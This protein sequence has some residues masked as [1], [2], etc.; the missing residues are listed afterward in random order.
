MLWE[1][2]DRICGKR[3]KALLP[4][5]IEAMEPVGSGGAVAAD[6]DQCRND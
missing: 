6:G 2:S 1:A 3:L 5:L 4:V